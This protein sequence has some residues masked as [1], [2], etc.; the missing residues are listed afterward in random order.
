LVTTDDLLGLGATSTNLMS[1]VDD[2]GPTEGTSADATT[3]NGGPTGT[4]LVP[5]PPAPIELEPDDGTHG[6]LR[7]SGLRD[8]RYRRRHGVAPFIRPASRRSRRKR[9]RDYRKLGF[10][11]LTQE[12]LK[13]RH[14]ILPRTVI[15]I[16]LMILALGVGAAFAGASLYAYYD[17]RQTQNET[18]VDAFADG[19]EKQY[20]AALGQLQAVRDQAIQ[21]V[22]DGLGPLQEWQNDAIAVVDLPTKVGGGVWTLRTAD[23]AGKPVVGSAF[24]VSSD[25]TSSLLLTTYET[26]AAATAQP[27]PAVTLDKGGEQLPTEVWTWDAER[28]LALLKVAKGGLPPLTWA[29]ES[30]W[31]TA[32][33][34]RVYAVSGLGGAGAKATGGMV[35]DQSA[36]GL[37]QSVPMSPDFRGGPIVTADG[38]VLAV[39]ASTYRPLGFDGGPLAYVPLVVMAC[40]KVLV[41]PAALTGATGAGQPGR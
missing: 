7:P 15:G 35:I 3:E 23:S 41:C 40:E 12:K 36:A 17:Y 1:D 20:A 27:G 24:V 25:A 13:L 29:P 4:A 22:N 31:G 5:A 14:R 28:D 37:Q 38:L 33:G 26:V 9:R 34:K 21:S 39:A 10:I 18:R 8:R 32:T 11:E 2:A 6:L 30:I 16:S 19:F